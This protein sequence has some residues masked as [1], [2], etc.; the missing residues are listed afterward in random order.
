M[1]SRQTA[2]QATAST[3]AHGEPPMVGD[4]ALEIRFLN[5]EAD[6]LAAEDMRFDPAPA[7]DIATQIYWGLE[8]AI[9]QQLLKGQAIGAI[10]D[11]LLP[12]YE[13]IAANIT[14]M[15]LEQRRVRVEA[16]TEEST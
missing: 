12:E 2:R 11:A 14:E 9:G 16:Y 4:D 3:I 1:E 13:Q 10:F 5:A 6:A 7:A 15:R 8:I